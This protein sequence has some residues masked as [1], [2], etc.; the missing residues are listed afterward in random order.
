MG[1]QLAACQ[2]AE[3]PFTLA[4]ELS[5]SVRADHCASLGNGAGAN[6]SSPAKSSMVRDMRHSCRHGTA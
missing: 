2:A 6:A 4:G 1:V 5:K 3:S